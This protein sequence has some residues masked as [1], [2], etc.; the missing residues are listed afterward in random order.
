MSDEYLEPITPE[1]VEKPTRDNTTKILVTV[2]VVSILCIC[3]CLCVFVL[4][5]AI[6]GPLVEEVFTDIEQQLLLT[7]LP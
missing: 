3:L 1:I 5:P 7:P 4:M 6:F 2:L